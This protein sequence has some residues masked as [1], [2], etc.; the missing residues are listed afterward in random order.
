VF[1]SA[2]R[3]IHKS[4][5]S[6]LTANPQ[7][8]WAE[9]R[10]EEWWSACRKALKEVV[11]QV[12][13]GEVQGLC[14]VGLSPALVCVDGR[15]EPVQPAP[16]WS[17]RRAQTEL[18]EVVDRLGP[19]SAFTV[20]PSLLWVKRHEP[21]KYNK[22]QYVFDSFNYISFKLTGRV[23][24]IQQAGELLSSEHIRTAG[25]DDKKFPGQVCRP[26]EVFGSLL[27]EV[28]AETGLPSGL[29]VIS[30]TIDAFAAWI[31]TGT[32]RRG[33]LC[34]TVGTSDGVAVVTERPLDDPNGRVH[35]IQ[36]VDRRNWIVGG[37]MSTG[38]LMLD[39]L[40]RCFYAGACDPYELAVREAS[41]VSPGADGLIALPYLVGERSPIFD[42]HAR[43]VFFGV[44][45]KHLRAH[46][47]RAA[48]ESVAFAVRDVAEAIIELG[49]EVEEARLAGRGAE[50][51]LWAQI[52][53]DV[54]G[55]PVIAPEVYDSSLLGAAIIAGWGVGS[56]ED[57]QAAAT[58]MA[59]SRAVFEPQEKAHSLYDGYFQLYRSLYQDL[60]SDFSQLYQ[61]TGR[62]LAG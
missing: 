49:G 8:G 7:P 24:W 32:V 62:D 34:N 3:L 43:G 23:N 48:L 56:F 11:A 20:L 59:R 22:T 50:N 10:P 28:A 2:G 51:G 55:T 60:K 12:E 30:G 19:K 5:D 52:K 37:A 39:W 15:G 41:T 57:L 29:P 35:C 1:D 61:L 21:L 38:G 17:D 16:I 13:P 33:L 31:G 53:A 45:D 47:V 58:S 42:P 54:L 27:P 25:L 14:V 9:Q 46:F 6:Y 40:V 36:H 4:E 18:A 44:S 26:G